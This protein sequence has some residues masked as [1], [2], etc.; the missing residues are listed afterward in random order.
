MYAKS[1]EDEILSFVKI[2]VPHPD[3]VQVTHIEGNPLI[4]EIRACKED[5]ADLVSKEKA[6]QV[7]A[8]SSGLLKGQFLLKFLEG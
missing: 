2:L 8:K 7:I 3:Q 1:V 5:L 4:F 6:I